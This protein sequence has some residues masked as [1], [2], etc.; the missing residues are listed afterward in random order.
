MSYCDDQYTKIPKPTATYTEIAKPEVSYT[1][2]GKATSPTYNIV[3]QPCL[4]LLAILTESSI[5]ILHEDSRV[6]VV[7]GAF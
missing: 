2:V 3:V 1:I 7:E 4:E 5:E 6:M